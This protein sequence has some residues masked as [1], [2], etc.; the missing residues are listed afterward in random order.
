MNRWINGWIAY[1]MDE[2]MDGWM[3]A[4]ID[5]CID[6]FHAFDGKING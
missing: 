4:W 1:C 2:Q 6:E 5:G 3:N